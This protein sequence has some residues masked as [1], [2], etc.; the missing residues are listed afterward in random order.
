ML[1]KKKLIVRLNSVSGK[2]AL[3]RYSNFDVPNNECELCI[4]NHYSSESCRKINC[5]DYDNL[6]TL[7][8]YIPYKRLYYNNAF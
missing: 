6:L 7:Y 8:T 3:K 4:F 1:L 2:V 5:C